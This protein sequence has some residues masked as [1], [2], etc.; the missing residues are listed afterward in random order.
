M[1]AEEVG[2]ANAID[3]LVK[4]LRK[5]AGDARRSAD[6]TLVSGFILFLGALAL[7]VFAGDIVIRESAPLLPSPPPVIFR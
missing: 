6:V 5:R 3:S 2:S 7:F 4:V 1:S